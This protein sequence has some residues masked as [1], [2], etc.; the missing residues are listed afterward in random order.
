MREAKHNNRSLDTIPYAKMVNAY[1]PCSHETKVNP[2]PS[3]SKQA[4][5]REKGTGMYTIACTY[6]LLERRNGRDTLQSQRKSV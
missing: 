5:C 4:R 2:V 3:Q 1:V 6:Y